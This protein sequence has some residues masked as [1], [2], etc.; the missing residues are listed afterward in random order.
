MLEQNTKEINKKMV[1]SL[2]L[3]A[4]VITGLIVCKMFDLYSFEGGLFYVL[5]YMGYLTTLSPAILYLLKVPDDFLKYYMSVMMTIF[6]SALGCYNGIGIYITFVLVP[7]SS[8]LYFERTYTVIC[9]VISYIMMCLSVYINSAGKY[10]VIY[11]GWSHMRTFV[12]YIIGFTMEYILV[13]IFLYQ[14]L[15]RANHLLEEQHEAYLQQKAQEARYQLLVN[16]IHD[17]IFEYYPKERIYRANRSLFEAESNENVELKVKDI[18]AELKLHPKLAHLL[19]YLHDGFTENQLSIEQVDMSYEKDGQKIPLWYQLECFVVRDKNQPVS[20]IGKFHDITSLV[21]AKQE[22]QKQRFSEVCEND[23]KKNSLYQQVQKESIHFTEQDFRA[24]SEGHRFLAKLVEGFK[25]EDDMVSAVNEALESVALYFKMDRIV[26]VETDLTLGVNMMNYQ[27]NREGIEPVENYLETMTQEQIHNTAQMY[28]TFGYIENNPK[29]KIQTES[30][31]KKYREEV[32]N[33]MCLGNQLWVPTL[34]E[35]NYSGAIGFDRKDTTPYTIVEKFLLLEIVNAISNIISQIR[36]QNENKAKSD[37]LSTMSHEIRTPMN[38]IVGMTE[39]ALREDMAPSVKK[40]LK[41]VKSS[42]FGLLTLINDILD[43]SKIEAGRFEI[44]PERFS[45]LSLLNDVKEMSHARNNGKLELRFLIPDDLPSVLY[46]DAV[47]I[48]QVMLNFCTNA[49]KYSDKGYM[50]VRMSMIDAAEEK[51]PWSEA[52][53]DSKRNKPVKW[54]T[55]AVEDSGIGIKQ[56]D[57]SK[58]FK[59]YSQVDTTVN[60]HKEGTGLGLAISKQLVEL[61]NGTVSVESVYGEGST[62]SFTIP[63][64]VV[65]AAP[66]GRLEDYEYEEIA[67]EDDESKKPLVAPTAKVLI[68]DD[69]EINLI[70]AEALMEPMQMQID[71]ADSG[72]TALSLLQDKT[73]DV[74]FMDHFMPGMDGVETT[75]KI[76]MMEGN[77]NQNTPIIALTADAMAGVKEKLLQSGMNDFITKPIIIELLYEVLRKW[78]PEE[79][80]EEV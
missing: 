48:K 18:D 63:L 50:E 74:I 19:N 27:W 77:S 1:K 29:N 6:I 26:V 7:V 45:M 25:Y 5:V 65:D 8:C 16:G 46:G 64:E 69:T 56:K 2:A 42:A 52:K 43:Y 66:A 10:E 73:Y 71:T 78:L 61:M 79:K 30:R 20:M 44:I 49:I 38:A 57:L 21:L 70:V 15:K 9:S 54:M 53:R 68:V 41:M 51:L 37:F 76:R 24:L 17:V 3:C 35:G 12:A 31:N 22:I 67:Q 11:M 13:A 60:H 40:K 59:F 28:D 75:Q 55:F 36:A 39:V 34:T 58:L 80:I 72:E 23:K 62:F 47:R 4:I 14:I 33:P 32:I